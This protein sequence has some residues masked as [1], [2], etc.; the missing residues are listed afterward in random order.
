MCN[1]KS[2]RAQRAH[3][4]SSWNPAPFHSQP[5]SDRENRL[6]AAPGA[7]R[8]QP[9]PFFS[10]VFSLVFGC[11]LVA[12]SFF[13]SGAYALDPSVQNGLNWLQGQIRTDGSIA[14]EGNSIATQLQVRSEAAYALRD[15]ESLPAS[16]ITAIQEEP[17]NNNEYLSRRLLVT[18]SAI[19]PSA[20]FDELSGR[21]NLDG[22]FGG[23]QWYESN[24]LDTAYALMAARS[25]AARGLDVSKIVAK[26]LSYLASNQA[27]DGGWARE[28]QAS[29]F[30]TASVLSAI[31]EWHSVYSVGGMTVKAKD[32]L[33]ASRTAG[34]YSNVMDTAGA[35]YALL[36]LTSAGDVIS[37]LSDA[38]RASQSPDG[39]WGV[40]PYLTALALRALWAASRPVDLG[41]TTGEISGRIVDATNGS[42]IS[43]AALQLVENIN[44]STA[45][46]ND[47]NFVLTGITPGIYTLRVSK[48]GF[49]PRQLAVT[50][51]AGQTTAFSDIVLKPQALTASI[52][53]VVKT[54]TGATIADAIV[55]VG[56]VSI[57]TNSS[58]AYSLTG[59]SP[60]VATIAVTKTGYQTVSAS[61]DFVAGAS[62]IFSPA[63]Y[64]SNAPTTATLKG[65]LSDATSGAAISGATVALGGVSKTTGTDGSFE[66]TNLALGPFSLT[67]S[68]TGY[69]GVIASGSVS[70]GINDLGKLS[71]QRVL[72]VSTLSGRVIDAESGLPLENASIKIQ[73]GAY[74][75]ISAV[76]GTY[77][78]ADVSGANFNVNVS[79]DGYQSTNYNLVLA[80][81]GNITAD[82]PLLKL[83]PS[84]ITLSDLAPSKGYY[85]PHDEF[86]VSFKINNT[87]TVSADLIV[88]VQVLDALNNLSFEIPANTVGLGP[89]PPNL[90]LTITAASSRE[91]E[92]SHFMTRESGGAHTILARAHDLNGRVVAEATTSFIVRDEAM[93]GGGL[94]INPPLAQAGTNT[95]VTF[96]AQLGNFGNQPIDSTTADLVVTLEHPDTNVATRTET[97]VSQIT[98]NALLNTSRSLARDK[99]GNLYTAKSNYNDG[100]ILKIE[101]SGNVSVFATVPKTTGAPSL[102][103]IL[104]DATDNIWV[105]DANSRIWTIAQSGAISEIKISAL[106]ALTGFDLTTAG[107][108]YASGTSAGKQ[109][110]VKRDGSGTETLLWTN[111]LSTPV[112]VVT[113][114]NGGYVVSNSGDGSLVKVSATGT[115]SIFATGLSAPKGIVRDSEGNYYVANSGAGSVV[116]VAAD[117]TLGIVATGLPQPA[118]LVL[119]GSDLYVTTWGDG[120]IYR[121]SLAGAVELFARG[122]ANRPQGMKFD[123]DGNL[124][125]ASDDGSLRKKDAAGLISVM[126]T[127]VSSPRSLDINNAGDIFI[128]S[129]GAG[130]VVR[131]SGAEKTNFATGLAGPYGV[132]V[133]PAGEVWVTEQ[134][135]NRI[136]RFAAD[137]GLLENIETML[138][139]PND[140]AVAPDGKVWVS[141]SGFI[142]LVEAGT[143][144]I[145][146]KERS[147]SKIAHDPAS[148]GLVALSSRDVYR[149]DGAGT[150]A[151]IKTLS[152]TSNGIAIDTAGDIIVTNGASLQKLDSAGNL[153]PLA[154]FPST[155]QSLCADNLGRNF[156]VA[157]YKLYRTET[158]YSVTALAVPN[159]E[160]A[161]WARCGADGQLLVWTTNSR[162]YRIN[163]D[164]AAFER[165]NGISSATVAITDPTGAIHV[166][167]SGN[168]D[169][170]RH[171]PAGLLMDRITGFSGPKDATWFEGGLRFIDATS[172]MFK[173]LPG[174][175]PTVVGGALSAAYL[176]T[177]GTDLFATNGSANLYKWNGSTWVSVRT[178]TGATNLTGIAARQDGS[179]AVADNTYSRVV[180]LEGT[181]YATLE[182]HGGLITPWGIAVAA[183]GAIYVADYASSTISRLAGQGEP[184]A[185]VA[186]VSSPRYL[187]AEPAGT[188]LVSR[189]SAVDRLNPSTGA[190]TTLPAVTGQPEKMLVDG[191][192]ILMVDSQGRIFKFESGAWSLLASGI[193]ST[194]ALGVQDDRVYLLNGNG[195]FTIYQSG[196][197]DVLADTHI[198]QPRSLTRTT[199]GWLV[200]G[201]GGALA[202]VDHGGAVT[203]IQIS[204]L[205]SNKPVYGLHEL[206]SETRGLLAGN[207]S[208]YA[209]YRLTITQPQL[210]PAAGTVVFSASLPVDSLP[211]GESLLS[212]DY[213]SWVP[214]YGG[215]FKAEVTVPGVIGAATNYLYVGPHAQGLLTTTSE[216]QAPGSQTVPF[217]L[218]VTGADFV[219]LSRV[220][221]GLIRPLTTIARPYGMVGDKSGNLW[222]TDSTHLYRKST[223]GVNETIVSG[224]SLAFGLAVDSQERFYLASKNASTGRYNLL[225][226]TTDGNVQTVADLGVTS[227]NGVAVNSRDEVFVGS[228]NKLLKIDPV[229]GSVST[230]TTVGLPNP[231]NI[232]MD[233]KDNIYVQNESD[234]VSMIKPDGSSVLLYSKGDG[235]V[236][237][238]FEGDGYPNIA[239]DCADNFYIAP[240]RWDVIKQSGEEHTLAQVVPRTGQVSALFDGLKISSRL[241]DID[242]LSFDRF[243]S[244][245]LMWADY[246]NEIWQVPVTCGAI[247]V[248]AH[249]IAQP[250]QTLSGFSRPPSAIVPLVD[251][252]SEYVFS[253]RDVT[254]Q[255]ASIGGVT[256]LTGLVLGESRPVMEGAY[257]VFQN[258]FSPQQV[259]LPIDVPTVRVRNLVDLAVSTDKAE[260]PSGDVAR[261]SGSIGNSNSRLISGDLRVEIEDASG[262]MVG[263]ALVQPAVIDSGESLPFETPYAIGTIMPGSYAAVARFYENNAVVAVARASFKVL[264]DQSQATANSKL[265][266]DRQSYAPSDRVQIG[267]RAT[268][269]SL[270]VIL[271]NLRLVVRVLDPAG[272]ELH[273]AEHPILQLAPAMS[274]AFTTAYAYR[275]AVPGTYRVEQTLLDSD[276]RIFDQHVVEYQVKSSADTGYGLTGSIMLSTPEYAV[277]E[278]M[279]VTLGVN[280]NGNAPISG[281]PLKVTILAPETQQ[282]LAEFPYTAS[283]GAGDVHLSSANWVATGIGGETYAVVLQAEVGGSAILLDQEVFRIKKDLV[284][285]E[286]THSLG[287]GTRLL[288]LAGCG[289]D[290]SLDANGVWACAQERVAMIDE[291]LTGLP[292]P[293]F[294]TRDPAVFLG[295][296]RSG[297]YNAYWVSGRV[298]KMH[299]YLDEELRE[300]AFRGEAIFIDGAHDERNKTLDDAIGIKITGKTG[301]QDLSVYLASPFD[302]VTL[303]S[304]GRGLRLGV[305]AGDIVGRFDSAANGLPAV[306]ANRYGFGHGLQYGFDLL[307]GVQ[308]NPGGWRKA[309]TQGLGWAQGP[310][311]NTQIAGEVIEY[312]VT[313]D[314]LGV[315]MAG[316]LHLTLPEG[317]AYLSADAPPFSAPASDNPQGVWKFSLSKDGRYTLSVLMR[318]PELPGNHVVVSEAGAFINGAYQRY[319]EPL[320]STI[321]VVSALSSLDLIKLEIQNLPITLAK[322]ITLRNKAA[323][324]I[325]AA[326]KAVASLDYATAI[327]QLAMAADVLA[328]IAPETVRSARY[329]V[330]RALKEAEW[331]WH[332]TQ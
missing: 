199:S 238:S 34:S 140:L 189:A 245:I 92:L 197:L 16:L 69:Q 260:Y 57:A 250:G 13:S 35:L 154:S 269:R 62:Y 211:S 41:A 100:R 179:L 21:Q 166:A 194:R 107:D 56:T 108:I 267:S 295:E 85:A 111:G 254:A 233:G 146:S 196:K 296:L 281:L 294:V 210:P 14:S 311:A 221:T 11:L 187:A 1:G 291:M 96:N 103:D 181:S 226:V 101:P 324:H 225:R 247:S 138:L 50:V 141:N 157:G 114:G 234:I 73:G 83:Q 321:S 240:Y 186:K 36:G 200:G 40:D 28:S 216:E 203:P 257:L 117:G 127:G 93:L 312:R 246:V 224:L 32:W 63:L 185:F 236:D 37:P 212:L 156:V 6:N 168:H 119:R 266:L 4:V 263:T 124:Y 235:V 3:E 163:P 19:D 158:D 27:A 115:V 323:T 219:T 129:Y 258:T 8:D 180:T 188:L 217:G 98:N 191:A 303:P 24:P 54:S 275:N 165:I 144:T 104:V 120:A 237:P 161:Y 70:G 47:G 128:A 125:V 306:V 17:E 122:L 228:S 231:R 169:L 297:A 261:V 276:G 214:P 2:M 18:T 118:D 314:N 116:K 136:K 205:V 112:G 327:A 61:I 202:L 271:E 45:S 232:A 284:K 244:R 60:G 248:E 255:G 148:G 145:W 193:N 299:E 308:V 241:S 292:V 131:V 320:T 142:T 33:L 280:N 162:L 67:L 285:L 87:N 25:L 159:N 58:G 251:G 330:G 44:F 242:Y 243:G 9:F 59:L 94:D 289:K 177:R 282:V 109:I 43:Q 252:R 12:L 192:R 208:G 147:Y 160:S 72:S 26:A 315:A 113:D 239:A 91:I 222:Y 10:R 329:S 132:A 325:E 313:V 270:N 134:T 110:L 135:Q 215:G 95:Q 301:Q 49:E 102:V 78:I 183:D 182:D 190:V 52:S 30:V 99:S 74:S 31:Q 223:S 268:N 204:S 171:D 318:L 309:F 178:V 213:G 287:N 300:A 88:V 209:I 66:Y 331:Q 123:A 152:A 218:N 307:G 256:E 174:Q 274:Q 130:T 53:G 288:V 46:G 77:S 298:D 172:R 220:E 20:V 51:V 278:T 106:S 84:G 71:L 167:V 105:A 126:A 133:D 121:V 206:S 259:Q 227:V 151:K 139:G 317:A 253:L 81:P 38:L 316:E 164:T 279:F 90:P 184:L 48:L 153:T 302:A 305:T 322:E 230:F 7:P 195:I 22:G 207:S 5:P 55:S 273:V 79:A 328:G 175:N 149:I 137:G 319:G 283:I 155:V 290:A 293:H 265:S 173:A 97:T 304:S 64:T 272:I 29:V 86:E 262:V 89:N 170:A 229:A 176:A 201:D 39:S 310:L 286:L 326:R 332:K 80:T 75:A 143:P 15:L 264:A 277:G 150:G 249:L 23:L 198:A 65:K 42:T 82:F 68:A 76:D